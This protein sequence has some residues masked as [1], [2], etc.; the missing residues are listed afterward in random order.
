[1]SANDSRVDVPDLQLSGVELF[2]GA[3]AGFAEHFVMFPFDTI[4]TRVQSGNLSSIRHALRQVW[5]EER[6]T[7]LYR[8]CTPVLVAAVP[9]HAV[10]FSFYESSK[11]LFG[12]GNVGI[13]AAACVATVGHDVVSTPFDV[14][15]QRMQMDHH[16]SFSSSLHCFMDVFQKG[17]IKSLTLSLP[18]TIL[19]NIPHYATYWLV[20]ETMMRQMHDGETTGLRKR[21]L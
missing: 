18:T 9:A 5:R 7:N 2:S 13:A 10:Y 21:G 6:L 12:E 20:Y 1:M 15:K 16:R 19:M 3:V 17:G 11:R 8:G 4:K 14:V